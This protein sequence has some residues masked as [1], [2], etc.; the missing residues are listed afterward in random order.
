MI[1]LI[2]ISLA[3]AFIS[4]VLTK[5]NGPL[6]AFSALRMKIGTFIAMKTSDYG[7][8]MNSD[9]SNKQRNYLVA[10]SKILRSFAELIT[11]P[12]CLGP[13]LV[14]VFVLFVD[15]N[16]LQNWLVGSGLLYI[17]L[18]VINGRN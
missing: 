8:E 18:G 14:L 6:F 9:I 2:Y 16:I 17:C 1:D 13:W 15:G 10:K 7:T 12:F 3:C 11:C 5:Q 4:N